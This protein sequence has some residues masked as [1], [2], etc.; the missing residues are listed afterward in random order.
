MQE[1]FEQQGKFTQEVLERLGSKFPLSDS[2]K[3]QCTKDYILHIVSE[4][5]DLLEQL[6]WKG[7]WSNPDKLI[8]SN[9]GIEIVDI[10]KFV[11]G[12]AKIW[13]MDYDKLLEMYD[14]KTAEV[15]HKWKQEKAL[16]DLQDRDRVCV[17]DIDGVLTPYPDCF[18]NWVKENYHVNI[19]KAD[20]VIWE[21]YKTLYRES[22]AKRSLPLITSSREALRKL[23]AK[24]YTI[25]LLTNRPTEKHKRIYSD[26]I[27]WLSD[28]QIPYHYIFWASDKK[29]LTIK[30][31]C[32]GIDFVVDDAP[33]T[34][35][36]FKKCGIKAYQYGK[37]IQSLLDID[38]LK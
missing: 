34:C 35:M 15:L 36:E 14:L 18:Y 11:W 19:K 20:T 16:H 4:C 29:I 26:T 12:L 28:C 9:I 27:T 37:D 31:K 22:G 10:Q 3:I 5:H 38:E 30:D 2:D 25:V 1:R 8:L 6:D 17:I 21:K 7:Y 23:H 32:K 13:D 33:I 24:G